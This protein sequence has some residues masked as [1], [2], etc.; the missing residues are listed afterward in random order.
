MT[1]CQ[2]LEG[3]LGTQTTVS[4]GS[5]PSLHSA[6]TPAVQAPNHFGKQAVPCIFFQKGLCLKGDRCAFLHGPNPTVNKA[7]QPTGASPATEPPTL[8]KASSA[9][10]KCT[11][12]QKV[13]PTNVSKAMVAPSGANKPTFKAENASQRNSVGIVRN[14][15]A[16]SNID[17]EFPQSKAGNV[18]LTVNGNSLSRSNR[19]HV[20]RALDEQSFHHGKDTEE[21]FR[22]SSPGFDVL[23]DNELGDSDYY[24]NED[25]Y[26][27]VG[28]DEG[29]NLNPVNDYD[30]VNSV[31]YNLVADMD[32]EAFR[33]PR[34]YDSYDRM[35]GAWEQQRASADRVLVGGSSHQERKSYS[36]AETP[37]Q[38]G[39]SDLRYR[40]S[41][42]RRVNGLRSVVNPDYAL[43]NQV[44]ERSQRSSSRGDTRHLSTHESSL[45]SRLRGRIKLPRSS[46]V[47][48][49]DLRSERE[50]DRGTNWGSL[51]PS[52][53]QT[54]H[55]GRLRDRIKGRVEDDYNN[56]GRNFRGP[57]VRRE[58][59]D[60]RNADFAGP[61]SLAELKG[62]KNAEGKEQQS[63]RKRKNL[64]DHQ[65]SAGDLSFDGPMPLS[66]ILKR[67]KAGTPV[68][69]GISSANKEDNNQK[70]SGESLVGSSNDTEAIGSISNVV[71]KD[72]ANNEEFQSVKSN[73]DGEAE[74]KTEV[75]HDEPSQLPNAS[76]VEA[77]DG[78][79]VEE[80]MEEHDLEADDHRDGDYEYEQGNEGEY[81]YEEG[82]NADAED[83]Y[84][85]DE[86]GDDFAKKIGV[87]FS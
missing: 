10:Q 45:S 73:A 66:E 14:A 17:N 44:E 57:E 40:L 61:K 23:V 65:Q 87:M 15:P 5:F 38:I 50:I 35:L 64:E 86:D 79:I 12:E 62:G 20:A 16:P 58:I 30:M 43:D 52:R 56:G 4:T 54:S 32:R 2:P 6:A 83:E 46:P 31:D 21:F 75:T 85:D 76:E 1:L 67:K 33:D 49:S 59:M 26:G 3:L 41:K 8:K 70:E 11:Q 34:R 36:K 69:S 22:E 81:N 9:L 51:S 48:G 39:E 82:E 84:L 71:P 7:P 74:R 24:Q 29:K 18:P 28:A 19:L 72:T 77:E 80:G 47:T 25:Q 78:M 63:L 13:L 60:D 53:P 68:A 27:R 37:N 42:R 55:Q